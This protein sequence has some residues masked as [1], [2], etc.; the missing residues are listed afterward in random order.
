MIMTASQSLIDELESSTAVSSIARRAATLRRVADLFLSGASL[1]N[2]DEIK[3][4]DDV[5][6]RLC[7]DIETVARAA[8][9]ARLADISHAP[10]K[11]ISRLA[12][13][14]AIEVAGPILSKSERLKDETLVEIAQTRGPAHMVAIAQRETL[15][16]AVTDA[17][18]ERGYDDAVLKILENPGARVS[19]AGYAKLVEQSGL[20]D[21]LAVALWM[22]ADVPRHHL[23]RLFV[24]ASEIVRAKLEATDRQ[25]ASMIRSVVAEVS[26]NLQAKARQHHRDYQ[27]AVA[28]VGS[29]HAAGRLDINALQ[30]F[31]NEQKFDETAVALSLLC[32]LPIGVIERGLAHKRAELIIV[33]ARAIGLGWD[34]T[35]SILLLRAN[36][37]K[38]SPKELDDA[39]ANF[40]K[41]KPE[42]ARKAIQ[43][44]RL[45]DQ[46]ERGRP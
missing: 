34:T 38:C 13:D 14:S 9:A 29:L 28:L 43:F 11:L 26:E 39:L 23:V 7:D 10:P 31:A 42:T 36:G 30:R 41:L 6:L 45:R 19:E 25:R 32:R 22:R 8:L 5:L 12:A 24:E 40:T 20:N 2:E 1:Y 4:F 16:E 15:A 18:I 46:T 27:A 35:R 21:R 37:S 44:Y 3:L 33:F 17:L